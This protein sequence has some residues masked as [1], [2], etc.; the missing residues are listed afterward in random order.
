[1]E[2]VTGLRPMRTRGSLDVSFLPWR[3]LTQ[4][5][6]AMPRQRV[7]HT[8]VAQVF[9]G[10]FPQR[11]ELIK[12]C[13]FPM[14]MAIVGYAIRG[15]PGVVAFDPSSPEV[16]T[17]ITASWSDPNGGV[18]NLTWRWAFRRQQAILRQ[19]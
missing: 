9:P 7:H 15:E 16:G 17:P 6:T 14:R 10:D 8:R 4:W 12:P 13:K 1:M 19:A 18:V 11:L 3:A 2:R 5:Y